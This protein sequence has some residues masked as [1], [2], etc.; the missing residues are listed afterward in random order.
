MRQER[1]LHSPHAACGEVVDNLRDIKNNFEL[2]NS[3]CAGQP[4]DIVSSL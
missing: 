2:S 4:L 1:D 3:F